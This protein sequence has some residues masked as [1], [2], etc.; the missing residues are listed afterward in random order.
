MKLSDVI[1]IEEVLYV[2]F[3]F[4]L[5]SM[6]KWGR[7]CISNKYKIVVFVKVMG[8]IRDELDE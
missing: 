1:D 5:K 8:I 2:L 4:V 3:L 6:W 7:E